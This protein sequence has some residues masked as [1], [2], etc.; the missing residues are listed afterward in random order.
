MT[1]KKKHCAADA[2]LS[3][4]SVGDWE[5]AF[6]TDC[7]KTQSVCFDTDCGAVKHAFGRDDDLP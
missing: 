6:C 7:G 1:K 4:T 3:Y 5:G 2:F